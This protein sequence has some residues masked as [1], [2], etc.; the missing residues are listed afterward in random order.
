MFLCF[1]FSFADDVDV[2]R[3]SEDYMTG[4]QEAFQERVESA[5]QDSSKLCSRATVLDVFAGV[6]TG[7]VVLK[8]LGIDIGKVIHVEHD[9][10]ATHVYRSNHD[11]SYCPELP[12]DGGIEHVCVS[13]FEELVKNV[14]VF[15]AKHGRK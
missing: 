1:F 12:D 5:K 15:L 8:R 11:R 13:T 7:I 3:T 10:I 9:K 6:G 2:L 14:E 4:I